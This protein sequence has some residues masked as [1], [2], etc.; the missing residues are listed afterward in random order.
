[1]HRRLPVTRERGGLS[2]LARAERAAETRGLR[3]RERAANRAELFRDRLESRA[4]GLAPS[5]SG[6]A[7]ER[8]E[9]RHRERAR[10]ERLESGLGAELA[11][12]NERPADHARG[13]AQHEQIERAR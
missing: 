9:Q 3:A 6:R 7:A 2:E 8:R 12:S 10:V 4:A 1:V 13:I 11:E 5:E